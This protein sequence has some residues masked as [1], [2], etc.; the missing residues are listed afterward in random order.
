MVGVSPSVWK[1]SSV[2]GST[3]R[4]CTSS[5]PALMSATTSECLRP[6]MFTPFTWDGEK[7]TSEETDSK[8]NGLREKMTERQEAGQRLGS[9]HNTSRRF[10]FMSCLTDRKTDLWFEWKQV[11]F[12]W[13]PFLPL[14]FSSTRI[15]YAQMETMTLLCKQAHISVRHACRRAYKR[16]TTPA[17][18]LQPH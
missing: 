14:H 5:P 15:N 17:P 12:A 16:Q 4:R 6:C 9:S 2:S 3:T 10:M 7:E 1:S 13:I 8:G 18:P 11:V